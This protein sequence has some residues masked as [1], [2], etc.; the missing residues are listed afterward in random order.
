MDEARSQLFI[1]KG[2]LT[3]SRVTGD[4]RGARDARRSRSLAGGTDRSLP[5]AA[6]SEHE[7]P[8]GL[9]PR[10][11]TSSRPSLEQVT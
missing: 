4:T 7:Q 5:P 10:A 6:P 11:S 3:R 2:L 8:T 1:T 9:T